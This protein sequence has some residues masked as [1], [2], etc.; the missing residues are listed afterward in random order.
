ME[1]YEKERWKEERDRCEM[2]FMFV[3]GVA[4]NGLLVSRRC[5]GRRVN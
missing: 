3:R 1:V 5:E 2:V 4:V